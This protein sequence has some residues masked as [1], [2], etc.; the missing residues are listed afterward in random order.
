MP[1]PRTVERTLPIPLQD[2]WRIQPIC[3]GGAKNDQFD[4]NGSVGPAK[5]RF[6]YY[7]SSERGRPKWL[8]ARPFTDWPGWP[9]PGSASVQDPPTVVILHTPPV[10]PM[11]W[12]TNAHPTSVTAVKTPTSAWNSPSTFSLRDYDVIPMECGSRTERDSLSV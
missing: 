5:Y 12:R 4:E 7:I 3:K 6:K 9:P 1:L 11:F 8:L 2:Y 10:N